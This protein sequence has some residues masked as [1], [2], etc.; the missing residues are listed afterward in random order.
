MLTAMNDRLK[1]HWTLQYNWH[2]IKL[3]FTDVAA[4]ILNSI[5]S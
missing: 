4:D 2:K 3:V 1:N 5:M